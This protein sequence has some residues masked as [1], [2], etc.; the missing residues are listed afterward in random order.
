MH[1]TVDEAKSHPGQD[2]QWHGHGA[3]G[4]NGQ[5]DDDAGQR[6]HRLPGQ[7]DAAEDNDEGDA[8]R[9]DE[10]GGRVCRQGDQ[11]ADGQEDRCVDADDQDQ[12]D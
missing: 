12:H 9:Q 1:Q 10:Q 3:I 7:V 5:G 11:R 6:G 2:R 8:C 4:C